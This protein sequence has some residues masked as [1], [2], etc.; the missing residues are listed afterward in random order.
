MNLYK[1]DNYALF[2]RTHR[3]RDIHILKFVTLKM[4]GK[5]KTYNI[6]RGAI[7]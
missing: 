2:V 1:S 3:Y 4:Y 7:R 5:V 6:R